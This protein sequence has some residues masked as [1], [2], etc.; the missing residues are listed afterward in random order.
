MK[1]EICYT[2]ILILLL[3]AGCARN[4]NTRREEPVSRCKPQA[5]SLRLQA[6]S[7]KPHY[8]LFT[9][10]YSLISLSD[11]P[12]YTPDTFTYYQPSYPGND[13]KKMKSL[14]IKHFA[15]H[16]EKCCDH[17]KTIDNPNQPIQLQAGNT[18]NEVFFTILR[19]GSDSSC[20]TR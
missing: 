17:F 1:P 9:F 3:L 16:R 19:T 8:S 4:E 20:F 12:F 6:T 11:K 10:H 2:V 5:A 15:N 14:H 7:P 18:A 13:L